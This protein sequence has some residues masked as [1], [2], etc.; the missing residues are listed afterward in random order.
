M[1]TKKDQSL[2]ILNDVITAALRAGLF[3]T[4]ADASIAHNAVIDI[5][6]RLTAYEQIRQNFGGDSKS[7]AGS[8][9]DSGTIQGDIPQKEKK[10]RK[11]RGSV[12][13][14]ATNGSG[15]RIETE[16]EKFVNQ[17]LPFIENGSSR[18]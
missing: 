14:S 16:K 4:L 10:E 3:N 11:R 17:D 18:T 15:V 8:G 2:V 13:G 7:A 5:E 12:D 6:Q 1:E 9:G